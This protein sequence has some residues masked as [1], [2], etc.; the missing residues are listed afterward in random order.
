MNA[1]SL[2]MS[3]QYDVINFAE[4]ITLHEC[5][6]FSFYF[7]CT[8]YKKKRRLLPFCL[9]CSCSKSILNFAISFSI[10]TEGISIEHRKYVITWM[11]YSM[12][13]I[14]YIQYTIVILNSL[15][16]FFIQ[17]Y[18]TQW[19][20]FLLCYINNLWKVTSQWEHQNIHFILK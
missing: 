6:C 10:K 13:Y 17:I 4:N 16:S 8:T 18:Y 11:K 15:F 5:F 1:S 14:T 12:Y 3:Q 19:N 7:I 2:L 9:W 20:G